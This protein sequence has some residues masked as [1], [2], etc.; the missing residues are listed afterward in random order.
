LSPEQARSFARDVHCDVLI[1]GAFL[2]NGGQL[3]LDTHWVSGR[4]GA[5]LGSATQTSAM[6]EILPLIADTADRVH[7]ELQLPDLAA[8]DAAAMFVVANPAAYRLYREAEERRSQWDAKSAIELYRQAAVLDPKSP[9]IPIGM[10]GAYSVLGREALAVEEASRAETLAAR[11]PREQALQVTAAAE[12]IRQ[13]PRKAADAYRTLLALRPGSVEYRRQLIGALSGSGQIAEAQTAISDAQKQLGNQDEDPRFDSTVSDHYSLVGDWARSLAWA[14]KGI[15]E[16]KRR[17]SLII[18]G[19]LLTTASQAHLHLKQYAEA[20][21]ETQEALAMAKRFDDYSGELRAL[22]RLGQIDVATGDL[23]QAEQVLN[24]AL[25]LE[26]ALG[27]SQRKIHT[28]GA[29]GDLAQK[30]GHS[31]EALA[32][33]QEQL[34]LATNFGYPDYI[35]LAKLNVANA[36]LQ[37]GD[38][39]AAEAGMRAVLALSR[40]VGDHDTESRAKKALAGLRQ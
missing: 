2:V 11:L 32:L 10:A 23:R 25:H 30:G 5:A 19:R 40:T 20:T 8:P 14:E 3:R 36:E 37:L 24:E 21:S 17:G 31:R 27:E 9:M 34:A 35:A 16:A 38:R 39:K 7:R 1:T 6:D 13:Q 28:L 29:L 18:Y 33:Y 4:T 15:A 26:Q 22:N 12:T